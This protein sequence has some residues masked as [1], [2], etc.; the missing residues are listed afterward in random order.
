MSRSAQTRILDALRHLE[1]EAAR[2]PPGNLRAPLAELDR[3][4]QDLPRDTDPELRHFLRQRSYEKA[5]L[6]LEGRLAEITRG[7]CT[8]DSG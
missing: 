7:G 1:A 8:R 6:F 4:T 2:T 3:L 5:R